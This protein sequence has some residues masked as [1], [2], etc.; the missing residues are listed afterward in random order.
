VPRVALTVLAVAAAALPGCAAVQAADRD[1]P[2]TAAAGVRADT[3]AGVA[4][5]I[6][7]QE[8][9]GAV[10][11]AAVRRLARDHALIAAMRGDQPAALRAAALRQL[12]NPGRHVVRLRILRGGRTLTDVGGRFVVSPARVTVHG[13]VIE[14][15]MQDV[16]GFVKLVH[17]LTGVQVVVRGAPGHV[18]SSLPDATETA[19]PASGNATIAGQPYVVRSFRE[20]GFGAEALRVWILIR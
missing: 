18:E 8:A 4:R 11:H 13:D 14:A 5:R 3:L 20:V 1:P 15:S 12:F 6:Y 7:R 17:R 2:A 9:A 16:V 19:L 10:G